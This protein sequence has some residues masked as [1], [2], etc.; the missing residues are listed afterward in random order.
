MLNSYTPKKCVGN[1][2]ITLFDLRTV[3]SS[4][5]SGKASNRTLGKMKNKKHENQ[6][7]E[8]KKL[9]PSKLTATKGIKS[10]IINTF[11]WKHVCN[12]KESNLIKYN[13][14]HVFLI[15]FYNHWLNEVYLNKPNVTESKYFEELTSF[16][17]Y[18]STE[19]AYLKRRSQKKGLTF[20]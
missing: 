12:V 14:N 15:E 20:F 19:I 6:S 13:I 18:V 9:D 2:L 7:K 16:S 10:N 5:V 3:L 17:D 8:Y 1:I 11:E 4:T